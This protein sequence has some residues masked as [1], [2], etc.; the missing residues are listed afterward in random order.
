[1]GNVC[2]F[3]STVN[4]Q[5]SSEITYINFLKS[6]SQFISSLLLLKKEAFYSK[7]YIQSKTVM[8]VFLVFVSIARRILHLRMHVLCNAD[9]SNIFLLF[10]L[11]SVVFCM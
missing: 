4:L 1:M 2:K 11:R 10:L 9:A 6:L 5:H 3:F 8:V 7:G